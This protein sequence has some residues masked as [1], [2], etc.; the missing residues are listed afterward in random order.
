VESTFQPDLQ[1]GSWDIPFFAKR[2]LDVDL[3]PG[4][5]RYKRRTRGSFAKRQ[6]Q[7]RLGPLVR[8]T[9][10]DLFQKDL[11]ALRVG[12]LDADYRLAGDRSQYPHTHGTER[13]GEIVGQGNDPP[14][15]DAGGRLELVH[16]DDRPRPDRNHFA[17]Y[18]EVGQFLL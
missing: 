16:R 4:Q 8:L 12:N 3:H 9:L 15:L 6:S 5:V 7:N 11:L 18:A 14:Y 2:F 13:H 17:L 10:Q 1:R